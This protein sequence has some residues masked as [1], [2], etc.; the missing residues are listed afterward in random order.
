MAAPRDIGTAISHAILYGRDQSLLGD[1]NGALA[2][3]DA[4]S[5]LEGIVESDTIPLHR[6]AARVLLCQGFPLLARDHLNQAV[7]ITEQAINSTRPLSLLVHRAYVL[8]VGC[9]EELNDNAAVLLEEAQQYIES[10]LDVNRASEYAKTPQYGKEYLEIYDFLIKIAMVGQLLRGRKG[11]N[12]K[13]NAAA[14]FSLLMQ[15][16]EAK[17]R[18]HDIH[19]IIASFLNYTGANQSVKRLTSILGSGG[20]PMVFRGL[21]SVGL[22]KTVG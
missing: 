6:E 1:F 12:V 16:L 7:A 3:L 10:H 13:N 18:Y 19:T 15:Y 21:W 5:K 20:V 8:G 2:T 4:A 9:R 14:K 22:A 11:L 17:Q